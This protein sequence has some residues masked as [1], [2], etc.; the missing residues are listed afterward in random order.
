VFA[1]FSLFWKFYLDTPNL[2]AQPFGNIANTAALS[3]IIAAL[4]KNSAFQPILTDISAP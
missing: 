4:T 3:S 1:R 2:G